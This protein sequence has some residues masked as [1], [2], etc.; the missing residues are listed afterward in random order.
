MFETWD[1]T[2]LIILSV[3][4]NISMVLFCPL[5]PTKQKVTYFFF[6]ISLLIQRFTVVNL[7]SSSLLND[8]LYY[9][10]VL[11]KKISSIYDS[12]PSSTNRTRI[13]LCFLA[14]CGMHT[15]CYA[16]KKGSTYIN[17]NDWYILWE[18]IG[19][20]FIN[21][22]MYIHMKYKTTCMR[23]GATSCWM[24]RIHETILSTMGNL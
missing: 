23:Y 15:S 17:F 24:Y 10:T 18:N 19:T 8:F 1:T 16:C 21:W 2:S 3:S 4:L 14:S 22:Y 20:I 9:F 13:S 6:N 7:L 5:S 12:R 11:S